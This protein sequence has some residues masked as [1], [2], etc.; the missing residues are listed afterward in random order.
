MRKK[1]ISGGVMSDKHGFQKLLYSLVFCAFVCALFALS[2]CDRRELTYYTE[3][4]FEIRAD[5]GGSKLDA[6][7]AGNGATAVFYPRDGGEPTIVLMG[8]RSYGKVRLRVGRYDALVFNRSFSEFGSIDFRG[9]RYRELEAYAH[10]IETRIDPVTRSETRVI[11]GSPEKIA[12]DGVEEI[13]VT[14]DML[15]NY[16]PSVQARNRSVSGGADDDFTFTFSPQ[17]LTREIKVVVNV[18]GLNN[19]RSAVGVLAGVAESVN[20]STGQVSGETVTQQFA[21]NEKE[22]TPGSP[23]NGTLT[24]RFNTFG[25]EAGVTRQLT[26]K[27]LLVDGKTRIEETF[28]VTAREEE[29]EDG[30]WVLYIEVDASPIADVKPEGGSD[31][32]FD[33]DVEDWGDET[34]HDIPL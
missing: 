3:A 26:L 7:E 13:E 32:G 19:V 9:D 4:E 27:A 30:T 2:G 12:A 10:H 20:L 34:D 21:L 31:S 23:F 5:W 16:S 29:A 11:V 6:E 15:G 8:D 14:E 33:A 25:F 18:I 24:G 1:V 28:D 17:C 22:F